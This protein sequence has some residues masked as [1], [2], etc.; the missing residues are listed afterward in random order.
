[1]ITYIGITEY[2]SLKRPSVHTLH[3]VAFDF[4]ERFLYRRAMDL[5]P[6]RYAI[7]RNAKRA[8]EV[9]VNPFFVRAGWRA[10]IVEKKSDVF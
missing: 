7:C 3:L 8:V 2:H 10:N 4:S 6:L 9:K 1:M 5:I